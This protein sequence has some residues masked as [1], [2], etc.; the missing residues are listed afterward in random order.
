MS[1]RIGRTR[2]QHSYP[3][4]KQAGSGGG[5]SGSFFATFAGIIQQGQSTIFLA[6]DVVGS[7]TFTP[8][9]YP[10][11]VPTITAHLAVTIQNNTVAPLTV[12]LLKNGVPVMSIVA[13]IIVPNGR[14]DISGPVG[15]NGTSDTFDVRVNTQ[16]T[17]GSAEVSATVQ[18]SP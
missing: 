5:S 15:Y 3:E 2:A 12:S 10:S 7:A 17:S 4:P 14:F 18:F 11:I 9:N 1:F 8:I 16:A 6:N 13:S